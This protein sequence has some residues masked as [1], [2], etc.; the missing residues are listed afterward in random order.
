M[1]QFLEFLTMTI[2]SYLFLAVGTNLLI[3]TTIN[4][5]ITAGFKIKNKLI[6][7][8]TYIKTKSNN[9]PKTIRFRL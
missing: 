7:I 2:L 6:N 1:L 5:K 4:V 3:A 8:P 9:T